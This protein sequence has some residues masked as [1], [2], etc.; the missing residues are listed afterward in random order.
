MITLTVAE[1]KDLAEFAGLAMNE[2]A[3]PDEDELDT[4]IQIINCPEGGVVN[5]DGTKS[6]F[7]HVAYLVDY[8]EE[9][10]CPLG[11]ELKADEDKG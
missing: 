10:C 8:P 5:D 6:R 7:A 3:M 2:D 4:E 1:I 11:D 9:G